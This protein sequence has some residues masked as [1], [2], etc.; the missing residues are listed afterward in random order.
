MDDILDKL[1]LLGYQKD[2][3][4]PM[5]LKPFHRFYFSIPATNLNE[6]FYHFT[7]LFAWLVRANQGTFDTP[8]QFDDPNATVASMAAKLKEMDMQADVGLNKLKQGYGDGVLAVLQSLVDGAVWKAGITFLPPVHK[9]DELSFFLPSFSMFFVTRGIRHKR[10][11]LIV[12]RYAEEAEVDADAEL[13]TESIEETVRA[14]DDADD[15]FV[16]RRGS[17]TEK[18]DQIAAQAADPKPKIDAAEWRLEVERVTP[19]LR[20]QI[21]NDNK[22]WRIHVENMRNHHKTITSSLSETQSQLDKLHAEIEK[23][24]EK[25]SSREKYINTQFEAQ[26]E[27]YRVLQDQGSELKQKYGVAST[28]VTELTNSL[29]RISEELDSVKSQ[30]DDIGSGMT[31]SKPLLSIKQGVIKLKAEVK[32]MDLRVGVIQHTLLAAKLKTRGPI[33]EQNNMMQMFAMAM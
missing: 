1:K 28:N 33:T 24:L 16:G 3:C 23:T 13:T 6:Q 4:K 10:S 8:G 11:D 5:N 21:P 22:D 32:Q 15:M 9:V 30:M 17:L 29:S 7:S 20:V 19:M 31:D 27:E 26:T 25:I 12:S 2:F 18:P 14:E